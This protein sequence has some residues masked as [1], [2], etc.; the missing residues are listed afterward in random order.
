MDA[1][2]SSAADLPH[3]DGSVDAA[4]EQIKRLLSTTQDFAVLLVYVHD[5][6]RLCA[7]IGH[8]DAQKVIAQFR[9]QLDEF[10]RGDS[11]I[12]Q[13]SD[14][15]FAVV[16]CN[17]RN[18]GHVQLAAQKIQRQI[19]A[20]SMAGKVEHSLTAAVG[21][22][23]GKRGYNSASDILRSA[24]IA[25]LEGRRVGQ[26][27]TFHAQATGDELVNEWD[28]ERKLA[29]ALEGGDLELHYQ[30][31]ICIKNNMVIGAEA[32]MRWNDPQLGAISPNIFIGVAESCGLITELTYF[33]IQRAC[34]QLDEWR[35]DVEKLT[36]A[37]NLSP[38]LIR[39]LEIVDV[40]K[41]AT[42]IWNIEP[43]EMVLEVTES[44]LMA[45]PKNTH[46]VLTA[47]RDLGAKVSLDDFGTGFS[48]FAYLK[49]IP[50]DELKIDRSFVMNM[51][52]DAGDRKIV[53]HAVAIAGSFGLKVVAEGVESMDA[54]AALRELNCDFAQGY[55]ISRPLAP[56]DFLSWYRTRRSNG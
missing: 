20:Q 55:Y 11:C 16:L 45:D 35:R 42:S 49:K 26:T 34:R 17:I 6:D 3:I 44:A 23:L 15:K 48:S 43:N 19:K 47:I 2:A 36:V 13:L 46:N 29:N 4:L 14:R 52:E 50:A 12:Y 53:E 41:S 24:E 5:V 54:L 22:A 7:T 56:D 8:A 25:L 33:A 1:Q 30:P 31:K 27:L 18:Q 40:I 39:N 10:R 32:L 51:L 37:V 28:L 38:S 9:G 21:A